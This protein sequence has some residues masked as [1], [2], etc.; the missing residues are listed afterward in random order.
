MSK[1]D[2]RRRYRS[3]SAHADFLVR[4]LGPDLRASGSVET[5]KDVIRCGRLMRAGRTNGSFSRYL[6]GTL[7]PDLRASGMNETAA[8][9]NRCAFSIR[10]RR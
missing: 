6:T 8:D 9:L 5:A 3:A 2:A 7:I 10:G 4:T 1:R